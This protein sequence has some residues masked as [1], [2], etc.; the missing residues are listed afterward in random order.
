[1]FI[2]PEISTYRRVFYTKYE[3]RILYRNILV[4]FCIIYYGTRVEM[5]Y[6]SRLKPRSS[7]R[8]PIKQIR[9]S[10]LPATKLSRMWTKGWGTSRWRESQAVE[11]NLAATWA[12]VSHIT[13]WWSEPVILPWA[14]PERQ[15]VCD[16][17]LYS[18]GKG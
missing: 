8:E 15:T 7:L 1:M 3:Q 17:P 14:N 6:F 2:M 16:W 10:T 11:A 18:W 12:H 4:S 5:K 9:D 13:E